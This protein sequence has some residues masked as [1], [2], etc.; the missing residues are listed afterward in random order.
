[1]GKSYN[2]KMIDEIKKAGFNTVCIPVK[3]E[4]NYT[5][6]NYTIDPA[7]MARVE[8]VVNYFIANDM[9]TV[10]NIHHNKIQDEFCEANKGRN[11][12]EG[13][14]IWKQGADNFKDYLLLRYKLNN[15]TN[16]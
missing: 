4:E 7:Y 9:Y 5:D 12:N 2:K 11:I 14:A 16:N 13:S 8:T 1:M 6:D 15:I 10:I 3:W